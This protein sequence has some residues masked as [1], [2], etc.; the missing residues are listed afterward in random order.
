MQ[1]INEEF[2]IHTAQAMTW[3]FMKEFEPIMAAAL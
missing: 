2:E 3:K 1:M